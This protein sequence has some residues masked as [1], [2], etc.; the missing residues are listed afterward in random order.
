MKEKRSLIQ[1][2]WLT[3]L[4]FFVVNSFLSFRM[5]QLGKE[6]KMEMSE[7]TDILSFKERLLNGKEWLLGSW[8]ANARLEKA[9]SHIDNALFALEMQNWYSSAFIISALLFLFIGYL[10]FIKD[11]KAPRIR[12][13]TLISVAALCLLNGI[14]MPMLEIGAYNLDLQIPIVFEDPFFHNKL[15]MSKEFS[16][17]MYYYY[18]NKSVVD[19]IGMLFA[20]K[21]FVVGVAI[22]SFSIL[23]PV[24][25]LSLSLL[26][27]ANRNI[28]HNTG[29]K[30]F[31]SKIGKWS[32]ADVFVAAAFLSYLSFNNMNSGIETEAHSLPG[33]YYF[34]AYCILSIASSLFIEKAIH[35]E[36]A[37]YRIEE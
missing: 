27:L 21:N 13:F 29:I 5:I 30:W 11:A 23:L 36:E 18:Q 28:R 25:K 2:F 24:L 26:M 19:L 14:F 9:Q 20:Q 17:H 6:Y 16:G 31:V 10:A 32:M 15:D 7:Y 22:L 35:L 8:E 33:L 12:A 37:A 1:L 3:L 34:L 4:F